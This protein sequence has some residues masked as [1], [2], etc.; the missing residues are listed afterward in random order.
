MLKLL[1]ELVEEALQEALQALKALIALDRSL[2]VQWQPHITPPVLDLWAANINEPC[3]VMDCVEVFEDLAAIPE[4]LP[5]LQV[6][7]PHYLSHL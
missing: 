5:R 4:V 1:P 2:A 3:T 6:T 7:S